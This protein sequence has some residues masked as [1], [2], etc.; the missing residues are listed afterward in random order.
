M[1]RPLGWAIHWLWA[2]VKEALLVFL[3][4]LLLVVVLL[5]FW[6]PWR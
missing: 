6:F 1:G 4:L 3:G 5:L 2:T